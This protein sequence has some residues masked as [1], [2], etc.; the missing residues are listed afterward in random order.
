MKIVKIT[1]VIVAT[2]V[3]FSSFA[4]KIDKPRRMQLIKSYAL[5]ANRLDLQTN[6]DSVDKAYALHTKVLK[7]DS[8]YVPSYC[9]K[10][11]IDY[12]RG[13]FKEA[14]HTA[15]YFVRSLP[16][17]GDAWIYLGVVQ[18]KLADSS[19]T[20]VSFKKAINIYD[21]ELA[22]TKD[23]SWQNSLKF[24]RAIT[25]NFLG[26]KEPVHTGSSADKKGNTQSTSSYINDIE[27]VEKYV[28]KFMTNHGIQ[29]F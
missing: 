15:N 5:E 27:T 13:N 18:T 19:G 3:S 24:K 16:D 7:L 8:K 25:L 10:I 12:K 29:F 1:S 23:R 14:L 20:L 11:S 26:F 17:F 4:Q 2:L 21:K 28:S 6:T 9:S 22:E